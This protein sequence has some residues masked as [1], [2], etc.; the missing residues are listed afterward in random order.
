MV[1]LCSIQTYTIGEPDA[2]LQRLCRVNCLWSL[3]RGRCNDTMVRPC[4]RKRL[5]NFNILYILFSSWLQLDLLNL[6]LRYMSSVGYGFLWNL[7]SYGNLSIS[8][9]NITW[10]STAS[11]NIDFWVTTTTATT[12]TASPFADLLRQFVDAVGHSPP[13]PF[14]STGFIQ[15][16][17]RYRT[18]AQLLEVQLL[19][20]L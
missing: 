9:E 3:T 19:V 1:H 8:P 7:P 17:N 5:N 2:F 6:N 12:S 14:Y 10:F 20:I 18:Q 16:K 11:Q 13:M 15:S 4:T